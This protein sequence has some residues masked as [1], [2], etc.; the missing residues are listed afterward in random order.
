MSEETK[1]KEYMKED[2][3][4]FDN[5]ST[6]ICKEENINYDEVLKQ[7]ERFE[8]TVVL[9]KI[10]P[11]YY[12]MRTILCFKQEDYETAFKY[13][14]GSLKYLLYIAKNTTQLTS[15]EQKNFEEYKANV[16]DQY[17]ILTQKK[18]EYQNTKNITL[19]NTIKFITSSDEKMLDAEIK[20]RVLIREKNNS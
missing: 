19:P 20:S 13:I 1:L 4:L 6:S 3:F 15:T 18:Q 12:V 7:C 2:A 8:S 11:S 5:I 16:I 9:F 17:K 10:L 14:N